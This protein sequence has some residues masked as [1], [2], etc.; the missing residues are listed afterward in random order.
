MNE[1]EI[2]APSQESAADT[3]HGT[4]KEVMAKTIAFCGE[5]GAKHNHDSNAVVSDLCANLLTCAIVN[6]D[7]GQLFANILAKAQAQA[8]QIWSQREREFANTEAVILA[9]NGGVMGRA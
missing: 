9:A 3:Y 8:E 2:L 1:T 4:Q 6:E 5:H 7:T